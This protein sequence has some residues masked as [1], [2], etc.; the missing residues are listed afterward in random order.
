MPGD[1][2]GGQVGELPPVRQPAEDLIH[3]VEGCEL[4]SADRSATRPPAVAA[5]PPVDLAGLKMVPAILATRRVKGGRDDHGVVQRAGEEARSGRGRK[6]VV[7]IAER[8]VHH[9]ERTPDARVGYIE[10]EGGIDHG[11]GRTAA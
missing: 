8:T 3:E 2:D 5:A 11:A 4:W 10:R 1:H 7:W 9:D 6:V